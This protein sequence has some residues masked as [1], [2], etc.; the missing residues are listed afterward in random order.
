M[1]EEG[2]FWIGLAEKFFGLVLLIL[3]ILMIYFTATSTDA[4]GAFAGFFTFLSAVILV[5]GAFLI[6]VKPPE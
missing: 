6:I 4:L 1:S 5:A 3:S 2:S